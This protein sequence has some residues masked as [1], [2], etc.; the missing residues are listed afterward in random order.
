[1][2]AQL[3]LFRAIPAAVVRMPPAAE[4]FGH[5]P[6]WINV[7]MCGGCEICGD[8]EEQQICARCIR[9][10]WRGFAPVGWP[11]GTARILNIVGE[12]DQLIEPFASQYD[13]KDA[14][15]REDPWEDVR[16]D[17]DWEDD[18]DD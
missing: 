6:A 1:V 9:L 17:P 12:D 3:P 10:F 13:G 2:T 7:G 11:C 8:A 5:V 16:G 15:E 14:L 4:T 18:S